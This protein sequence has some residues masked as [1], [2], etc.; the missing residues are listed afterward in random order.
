MGEWTVDINEKDFEQ[1][2]LERSYSV[3]VVLDF[4]APWCGPCR[5]IG[6]VLE[7]LADEQ[8]G[9][10]VLAK[11]NVDENPALAQSFQIS[12]I[13]AVKAVK[14]GA[15][16]NEFLGA[17]PEPAIRQFIEELMPSEA[18]SLAQQGQDLQD[19]GKD[20]GAES[21]Y[22]AALSKDE[23]QPKALLGL[24][25]LLMGK[26]EHAGRAYPAWSYPPTYAGAF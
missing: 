26:E 5:A 18:D 25:R 3:P 21:L 14:E 10:F 12:S 22:R 6:P 1:D 8:A 16:A 19:Q 23:R 15:I 7:K 9:K 2:V 11:V 20:Q 24:A 13:P 17:L 4:W